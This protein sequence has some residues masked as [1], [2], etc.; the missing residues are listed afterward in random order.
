MHGYILLFTQ[1][2]PD[3]N[4]ISELLMP[5]CEWNEDQDETADL[6]LDSW[7]IGGRYCG[8]I[9]AKVSTIRPA[10]DGGYSQ[11]FKN[12]NGVEIRSNLL[13]IIQNHYKCTGNVWSYDETHY[14]GYMLTKDYTLKVDGAY[15]RNV[16]NELICY[17][18]IS[19][20]G[21][22]VCRDNC[23]EDFDLT[24]KEVIARY[25]ALNGFVTGIDIHF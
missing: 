17:G 1:D 21:E 24:C 14:F 11:S 8:D 12:I 25:K 13:D 4:R 5:F 23:N 19:D 18:Y 9:E 10:E 3:N 7:I 15:L 6:Y 20:L 2:I 22:C 16:T